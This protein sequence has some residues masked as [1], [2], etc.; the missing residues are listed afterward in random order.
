MQAGRQP[1][2]RASAP[3]RCGVLGQDAITGLRP[4]SEALVTHLSGC[5]LTE[6]SA[7]DADRPHAAEHS[8]EIVDLAM[9]MSA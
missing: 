1:L 2:W 9:D 4:A 7:H 6:A 3:C 8:T 5:R